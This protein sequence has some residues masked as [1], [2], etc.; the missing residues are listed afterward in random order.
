MT[1]AAPVQTQQATATSVRLTLHNPSPYERG[2]IVITKWKPISELLGNPSHVRVYRDYDSGNRVELTAQIDHIDPAD[3]TRDQLVFVLNDK[4]SRGDEDYRKSC[5]DVVVE[6]ADPYSPAAGPQAIK[7]LH[8]VKFDN[9]RFILWLNTASHHNAPNNHWFGGAVTSARLNNAELLD[10]IA[11]D[12]GFPHDPDKRAL[13]VDRIHLVRGPWDEDGSFDAYIF[14][15]PWKCVAVASGP[16]RATALIVSSSF[17]FKCRDADQVQRTFK[18][19]VHRAASIYAGSDLIVEKMWVRADVDGET[20]P[21]DLWFSP[22]YFMLVNLSLEAIQFRYPDHPGWFA[23]LAER[24]PQHGYAFATDSYA[25]AIW[26][27]PLD[28]RNRETRHRAYSWELGATRE[29]NCVHL[30]RRDSTTQ[31][32]TDA[33]GWAWYDLT[34]KPL[35]AELVP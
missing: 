20:G 3:D 35:R 4:L 1:A 26:H 8:G 28:H 29:A 33:I 12:L 24:A 31:A 18:C 9:G 22:R 2:G 13:Q 27:P 23:V 17:E 7:L 30:F 16:L 14:N 6:V 10:P 19:A 32:L 21:V 11:D 34:Y 25:G 5:G 15:Q